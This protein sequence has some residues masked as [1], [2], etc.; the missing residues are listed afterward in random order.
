M[1]TEV[2]RLTLAEILAKIPAETIKQFD[3]EYN[4]EKTFRAVP[5]SRVLDLAFEAVDLPKQ[6]YVLRAKDGYTVPMRGSLALEQGAYLA[7]EDTEVPGWEPVGERRENPGPFYLIWAKKEQTS[8]ETHPRPYQLVSIEIA[9]FED[10]FP[11]TVP[12][13]IAEGAPAR[14]GFETFREQCIL[15][16]AINR[17][18]GR[19]GPE[20]NVPQS[21]VEYRPVDQVKAYIKNPL[22]FR[23][24]QMPPHP[25][26]SD[27]DLDDLVAYFTA[28]KGRKQDSDAA[29]SP[30]PSA[31]ASAAPS[32]APSSSAAVP[33]ARPPVPGSDVSKTPSMGLGSRN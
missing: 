3:P 13:G 2:K 20:L 17:E 30:P 18:G 9:K 33:K 23:Y 4:R 22:T 21:I 25:T 27:E 28:M 11:K 16:H 8:L 31:S 12:T 26:L 24:S 29:A 5:F 14:R 19:V 10:L 6:E 1:G 15:C 32:S 7:F